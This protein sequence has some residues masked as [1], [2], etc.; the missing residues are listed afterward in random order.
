[1]KIE[2]DE[3]KRLITLAKRNIDFL[4][5]VEILVSPHVVLEARSE[6]EQRKIAVGILDGSYFAVI[7]TM[8]G[9]NYR[10]ITARKARRDEREKYEELFSGGNPENEDGNG[11]E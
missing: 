7:Y 10:V 3:N 1:M 5:M 2:F 8:R 6:I 9:E 4:D 11:L